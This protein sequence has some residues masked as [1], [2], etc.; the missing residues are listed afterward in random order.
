MKHFLQDDFKKAQIQVKEASP[1]TSIS[2][3]KGVHVR[4]MANTRALFSLF[5]LIVLFFIVLFGHLVWTIDPKEQDL[6]RISEPPSFGKHAIVVNNIS[7]EEFAGI[8]NDLL[9]VDIPS[10]IKVSLVWPK[11]DSN[12]AISRA[13]SDNK[14][15][16]VFVGETDESYFD[17][18]VALD[19]GLLN[20]SVVCDNGYNKNIE[21][22]VQKGISLS[23]AQI[24][25]PKAVSGDIVALTSHPFGTDY[26]GRDILARIINGARLS[27][28]I[29][30]FA[31]ILFTLLGTLIGGL[32]GYLGGRIDMCLVSLIDIIS[33]LPFL[34]FLILFRVALGVGPGESGVIAIILSLVLLEWTSAA[35]LMRG[36]A[37]QFRECE[38][39]Y[40]ARALG[41]TP[42][43]ILMRHIVPNTI[44]V[45]IVYLTLAIPSVIFA[46]AF[47]S[48]LGM[49]IIS[50][51][52][53]LGSLCREGLY[54]LLTNP[55]E[56][57]FPSLFITV[58][59]LALN[60]F[61]NNLRDILDP[62]TKLT[63]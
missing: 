51:A 17:D 9:I 12:C 27:L 54:S 1:R 42:V 18:K 31:P 32:S 36:Q 13:R 60:M 45:M 20:Y 38:Y 2:Y 57:I 28:F 4:L 47:L 3:W 30:I 15:A 55:S 41:A 37:L 40:A 53:S 23:E 33:V 16:P 52:I 10:T 62:K 43:Y 46:E 7:A 44:G 21:V 59:I 49:G 61:G 56:V 35:R 63:S 8:A 22:N 39:V 19:E 5:I 34:L 24:R 48:F 25:F 50:P 14:L 29:G 6:N 26:L 58:V 11:T